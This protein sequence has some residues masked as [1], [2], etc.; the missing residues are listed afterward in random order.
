MVEDEY[1]T[2][3]KILDKKFCTSEKC[4]LYLI[5]WEDYPSEENTWEP[6]ENLESCPGVL[7]EF[8]KHWENSLSSKRK[9]TNSPKPSKKPKPTQITKGCVRP[10]LGSDKPA[11][12]IGCRVFQGKVFFALMF[13]QRENGELPIAGVYSK[14]DLV[15]FAPALLANYLLDNY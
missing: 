9:S 11:K 6:Q 4:W 7:E 2:I 10:Q 13:K 15:K 1:F 14:A 3:E 12:I 8:N 5:K